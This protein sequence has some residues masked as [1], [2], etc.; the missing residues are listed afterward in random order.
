MTPET[1]GNNIKNKAGFYK[2]K[3]T[4]VVVEVGENPEIGSGQA[5]A[6]VQVGF[7]YVG[8]ENPEVK[9]PEVKKTK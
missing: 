2:H 6:F 7:V 3:E 4:G 8:T 1:K 5:D 9:A